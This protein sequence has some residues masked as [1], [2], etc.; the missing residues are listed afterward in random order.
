MA[1]IV[2]FKSV[3]PQL[4][5]DFYIDS[6]GFEMWLDQGACKIMHHENLILGFCKGDNAETQGMITLYYPTREAVDEMYQKLKT[7][8]T[9]VP[10]YNQAYNIYQFFA[11]D[12]EGRALEFQ[13]FC[14][15]LTAIP[16]VKSQE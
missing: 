13:H 9:C 10:R 1:G 12:P 2:F 14:H 3:D 8:A 15:P 5:V 16:T 7:I 6:L 11:V 4:M